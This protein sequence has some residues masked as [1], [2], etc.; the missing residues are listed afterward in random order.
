MYE[1]WYDYI[2]AKYQKNAK[3]C[4]MDTDSFLIHIKTENVYEDIAGDVEKAFGTPNY[5]V[6]RPLLTETNKK[7]VG[8]ID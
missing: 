2:K 7:V 5:R 1:L 4:Y 6:N 8:L 3:L